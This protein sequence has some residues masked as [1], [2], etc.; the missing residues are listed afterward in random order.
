ML[1]IVF[2]LAA[3]LR[4]SFLSLHDA[5]PICVRGRRSRG[6]GQYRPVARLLERDH[7]QVAG[8]A[9]N[10]AGARGGRT[11][12]RESTRLNSSHTVKS[13]TVFCLKKKTCSSL[14]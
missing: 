12:D 6:A 1:V 3:T 8:C 10:P 4:I 9:E 13:Y 2:M 7:R 5:L 11:R 14:R